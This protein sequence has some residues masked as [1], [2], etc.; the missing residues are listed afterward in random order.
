MGLQLRFEV[1]GTAARLRLDHNRL[2]CAACGPPRRPHR[3]RIS[4]EQVRMAPDTEE[5]P[6][7]NFAALISELV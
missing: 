2:R 7:Q 3:G 4:S 5:D 6:F 1:R